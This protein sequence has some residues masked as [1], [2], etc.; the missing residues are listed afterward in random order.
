MVAGVVVGQR[1]RGQ[2]RSVVS[3]GVE[4]SVRGWLGGWGRRPE[5][6]AGAAFL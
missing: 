2:F 6:G 1:D 3:S 4:L 5:F